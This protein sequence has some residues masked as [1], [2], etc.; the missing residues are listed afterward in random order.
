MDFISHKGLYIPSHS[1][2]EARYSRPI[3]FDLF[4][5]CG[6]FSLGFMQAGWEIV[7]AVEWEP[8]AAITY[9][10]NL[11]SYPINIHY[12]EPGD[13][14]RLNK[15]LENCMRLKKNNEKQNNDKHWWNTH[16][17]IYTHALGSHLSGSGWI[18]HN[19][20]TPPVR[21]FWF[22]DIRKIKG[23]DILDALGLELGDI[24]C[25]CGGPPCQGFSSAGK[26]EVMDPRNS[27]VFEYG[28]IILEIQPKT[29]VMENVPG[30]LNMV[31]PEGIPVVDALAL[32]LS[33]GGYGAYEALK[34]T[35]LSTAGCGVGI[36]G[37]KKVE[38]QKHDEDTDDDFEDKIGVETETPVKRKVKAEKYEQVSLF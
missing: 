36:K 23:Q 35:I 24:D 37:S 8:N 29:F 2:K 31:T 30:I 16:H 25:I 4:A 12:A 13:K 27:L 20:A 17:G 19:P 9:M 32:M 1:T 6:G 11:G 15:A 26:H 7:G 5:G 28:R 33:K 3:A 21:N 34:K 22:G 38:R 10:T 14:E 18:K